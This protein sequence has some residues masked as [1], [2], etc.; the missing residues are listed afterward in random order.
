MGENRNFGMME[1][2]NAGEGREGWKAGRM[3]GHVDAESTFPCRNVIALIEKNLDSW[4][5]ENSWTVK[6]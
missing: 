6:T 3:V 5:T 4:D 1:G 2:W